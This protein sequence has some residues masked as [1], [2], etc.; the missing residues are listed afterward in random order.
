[1]IKN[2]LNLFF[3]QICSACSNHLSDNELQICTTCRH[4]LPLTNFHD[5]PNNAVHKILYG[6]VKLQQATALLH[7]SKKGI[8]QQMMHNLKYRGQEQ[9]G[10]FLGEWLGELLKP[11]SSYQDIDVVISV[12]LHKAKLKS[13]GYNQVDKFAK[14]IAK[15]LH[16]EYNT[17]MLVKTTNTKTQVFKDRLKRQ[18]SAHSNFEIQNG[19]TLKDKHILLVD[20][21]I[22]TGATIEDC[23]N[24]LLKIEGV[25]LSLA[26]MAITD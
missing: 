11:M 6:R 9:I 4:Q 19:M 10:E 25:K 17:T 22:T 5:D 21:I 23:A 7:F 12:P 24:Q 1:M 8:V 15:S 3:P 14:A 20:D 2:L 13:R 18:S 16:A 26:T